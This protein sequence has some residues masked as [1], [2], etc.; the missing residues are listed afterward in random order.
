MTAPNWTIHTIWT[1]DYLTSPPCARLVPRFL[2]EPATSS[3]TGEQPS[4]T[5]AYKKGRCN[6][7]AHLKRI[8]APCQAP[9]PRTVTRT[10]LPR[11]AQKIDE[12]RF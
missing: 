1:D 5:T 6:E 2:S 4:Q 11:T 7:F 10:T 3:W 12:R 9:A 8:D